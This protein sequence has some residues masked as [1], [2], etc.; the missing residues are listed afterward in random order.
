MAKIAIFGA[1]SAIAAACARQWIAE[2]NSIF[3]IGRNSDR[4]KTIS[5]DLGVRKGADQIVAHACADLNN[6]TRHASLLAEAQRSLGGLDIV[7]IAHGSLPDQK[8]C[9]ASVQLTLDEINTNALST[10]SIATLAANFF[11]REKRGVLVVVGSVAGDRGRESN[12]V[13]GAAKGM[14][15][16][17]FAGLRSRLAKS[18]V[19][20]VTIKP[21]FVDTPMTAHLE[22][23]G[24][25]WAQPEDIARG[26]ASAVSRRRDVVYLPW[27]W[28]LIMLV[29]RHIPEA[30]FKRLSL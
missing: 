12:Y 9:E 8:A 23:K 7:L 28:Q 26:I 19:A 4:L 13:Y 16:V 22:K 6:F 2:G 29:I 10:I 1:N 27:I 11:E 25:L 30:V 17:F 21:G 18:G 5:D 24:P 3:L 14:V 20:V 15:S